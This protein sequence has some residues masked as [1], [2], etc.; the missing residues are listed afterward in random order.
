MSSQSEILAFLHSRGLAAQPKALRGLRKYLAETIGQLPAAPFLR[1]PREELPGAEADALEKVGFDL[2]PRDLG[3]PDPLARTTAIYAAILEDSLSVKE[4]GRLLKVN[5]SRVR[6]RLALERSLYGVKVRSEWRVPRLQFERDRPIPGI[7]EVFPNL[8]PALHP[9]A[10]YSWFTT[11]N[12]DLELDSQG[13]QGKHRLLSPRA[14]L[15]L[16]NSPAAVAELATD[17]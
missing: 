17:L 10:V 14:W 13:A 1:N 9:V 2:R 4:A 15:L 11:P 16:G 8:S 12:P 3:K 6:Q 5:E 7:E